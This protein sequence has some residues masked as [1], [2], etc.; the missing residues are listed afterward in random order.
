[1]DVT[2]LYIHPTLPP[3]LV[4]EKGK[5]PAIAKKLKEVEA[6]N[7][8][9]AKQ[10]LTGGKSYLLNLGFKEKHI[11]TIHRQKEI[12]VARDICRLADT[13]QVD[14]IMI[15]TRGRT[16]LQSF[17]MGEVSRRVLEYCPETPTWMLEP[18]V[19]KRGVLIAVDSSEN[20]LRAADHAG[21]MLSGTDC[22]VTLF[23]VRRQLQSYVPKEIL[24]ESPDLEDLWKDTEELQISPYIQKAKEKLLKNGLAE[25]QIA[26]KL[27]RSR[28]NVSADI[29]KAAKDYDCGTVV[30]G[31]RGLTGVKEIIT[32]SVTR[33]ILESFSGMAV[34]IVR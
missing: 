6:K 19:R 33:K 8:E 23:H 27:W 18:V 28:G 10:V 11:K 25:D 32:G 1:L 29:R 34:W 20:A 3:L 30:L 4:E 24:Q 12:G 5:N 2:L 31:R 16:R 15:S 17:F 7:K 9:M 14:T 22:P 13:E 21:F 26:V